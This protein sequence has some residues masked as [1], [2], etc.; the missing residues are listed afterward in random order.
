MGTHNLNMMGNMPVAHMLMQE[1][2]DRLDAALRLVDEPPGEVSRLAALVATRAG[3]GQVRQ[4]TIRAVVA[5]CRL[6]AQPH[7]FPDA[8][9]AA[10]ASGCAASKAR[11]WRR[12]ISA[13]IQSEGAAAAVAAGAGGAGPSGVSDGAAPPHCAPSE[14]A[15]LGGLLDLARQEQPGQPGGPPPSPP[16]SPPGADDR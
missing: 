6:M 11:E 1:L 14:V 7:A 10:K 9:A 12:K 15:A 3:A 8:E 2:L 4:G 16:P 5:A 13:V